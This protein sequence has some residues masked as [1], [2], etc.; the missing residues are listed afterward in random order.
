[1]LELVGVSQDF[2]VSAN[3]RFG[4]TQYMHGF[5]NPASPTALDAKAGDPSQAFVVPSEQFRSS[6]VFLAP[7]DYTS[8][9]VNVIAPAGASIAIDGAR[10]A[11]QL[12]PVA[13][14]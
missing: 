2:R 13:T 10:C 1:V 6:Y 4:V 11:G 3:A 14:T 8:S 7:N 5:G 9:Y 12:G